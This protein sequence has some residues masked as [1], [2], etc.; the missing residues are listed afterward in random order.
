M[1]RSM[2]GKNGS[3]P[4]TATTGRILACIRSI[5]IGCVMSYGDVAKC[6][7]SRSPRQ[8]GNLLAAVNHSVPW[9]RVVHADG[10]LAPRPHDLQRQRLITEGVRFLGSR[11]DINAHRRTPG[12]R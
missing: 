7:G 8:V 12:V 6:A 4:A 11:V 3:A 1:A 5:P 10:T 2:T 9:H